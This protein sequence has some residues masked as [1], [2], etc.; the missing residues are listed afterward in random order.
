MASMASGL[1][2]K[3]I[4]GEFKPSTRNVKQSPNWFAHRSKNWVG[5]AIICKV[6]SNAGSLGPSGNLIDFFV[7]NPVQS[8]RN[9]PGERL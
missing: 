7:E 1:L 9:L 2:K 6:W 3:T 4:G 5:W 8:A